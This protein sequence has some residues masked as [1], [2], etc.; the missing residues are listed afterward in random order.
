M[1]GSLSAPV[2]VLALIG[3]LAVFT[4]VVSLV[5]V[6]VSP[7]Y[8]SFSSAVAAVHGRDA[9][10]TERGTAPGDAE[11]DLEGTAWPA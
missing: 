7:S 4:E 8:V 10:W 9:M 2:L 11:N 6:G 3:A 5:R 1:S